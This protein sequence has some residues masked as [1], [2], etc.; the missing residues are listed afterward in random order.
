MKTD[1]LVVGAGPAGSAAALVLAR[2]GLSVVLADRHDFPRD[3]SCGDALLP[4]SLA[5]LSRLGIAG[6]VLEGG[7]ELDRLHVHS[8]GGH[9]AEIRGRFASLP[10]HA[11]DDLLRDEAVL[12]GA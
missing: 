2:A 12:A 9:R 7:L 5:A 1:V 11:L 6:R 3:K 10:R 4:D 8:P